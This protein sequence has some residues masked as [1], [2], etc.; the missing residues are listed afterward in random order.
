M[1]NGPDLNIGT[2][3]DY[4][5]WVIETRLG[6]IPVCAWRTPYPEDARKRL[7]VL[8]SAHPGLTFCAIRQVTTRTEED[9]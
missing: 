2:R 3:G 7:E 6:G 5:H 1:S 9:W 4:P 8:R